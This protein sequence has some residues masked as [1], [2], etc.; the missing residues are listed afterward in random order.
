MKIT[1]K[2]GFSLVMA[3]MIVT[4]LI[5]MAAGFFSITRYS[6]RSINTNVENLRLYWAAESASNYNVNWWVNQPDS[7]RKEWPSVYFTPAAKSMI[8]DDF[9][10]KIDEDKFPKA[11]GTTQDGFLYM[12]ASSVYEGNADETNSDL[13][14]YDGLKLI[15]TRYKGLRKNRTE[16]AV[17]VLDS[18]AYNPST[19]DI[20]N[21]CLANVYNY[22]RIA[23]LEPFIHSELINATMAGTG[24]HG[25]KGRFNEQDYRYGPCYYADLVHYDYRTGNTKYGP[26][27]YGLVKSAAWTRMDPAYIVDPFAPVPNTI[28]WYK[29]EVSRFT[30][31]NGYY[32]QGLGLNSSKIGS[33][34][35]GEAWA[36]YSLV[37]GYDKHAKLLNVD[38]V[39][40]TWESIETEGPANGLYF[41]D[42]DFSSTGSVTVKLN[43]DTGTN[44]TS[45]VITNGGKTKTLN[46]GDAP[47]SFKGIA[48]REKFGTVYL[49][50]V[51][52]EDFSLITQKDQVQITDH[53]Y[54][55]GADGIKTDVQAYVTAGTVMKPDSAMLGKIWKKM[56]NVKGHLAVIAGLDMTAD[57]VDK[58]APIYVQDNNKMVFSTA[59]YISQLGE[60]NSKG[61]GNTSQCMY[62]I[63]PVMTLDTQTKM[64]G[65]SDTAQ[66]WSK[67][68]I[69]DRRYLNEDE[70]LPPFCGEDPGAHPNEDTDGLNRN[71]RWSNTTFGHTSDW[72]KIVWRNGKPNF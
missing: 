49:N 32:Y 48:V 59:A 35:D 55:H 1:N 26:K 56:N 72:E 24:F 11:D 10:T 43:Y 34:A 17:W 2:K 41:M 25:V 5:I 68:Y 8:K 38:A 66:K 60:L 62:N 30:N 69:Q 18:Y 19:G 40:W 13:E 20:A 65:P 4:V 52:N 37:G 58:M 15:T 71:H 22:M 50:G 28:S 67:V 21:I 31:P 14:G 16:E 44:V 3:I 45:A 42:A 47:G 23:E 9:G 70:E 57:E 53:F 39:V 6:T 54:V 33:E 12:H 46:I 64:T 63:G 61:T 27:F 36:K 7:I 51:S 29:N